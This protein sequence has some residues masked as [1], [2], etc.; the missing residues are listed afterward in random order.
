MLYDCHSIRSEIPYLFDGLLPVFNIGSNDGATCAPGFE[1][2][3][4]QVCAATGLDWVLNGLDGLR[5]I[6][7]DLTHPEIGIPVVRA[8]V[9]GLEDGVG[10]PG[11]LPGRRALAHTLKRMLEEGAA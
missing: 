5:P 1:A 8:I 2:D 11:Y 3:V 10:T 6:L 9:P 7:V 4:T